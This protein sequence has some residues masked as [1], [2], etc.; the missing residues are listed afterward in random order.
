MYLDPG[1]QSQRGVTDRGTV[2]QASCL[3]QWAKKLETDLEVVLVTYAD[4]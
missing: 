4:E 1:G 2:A 3:E